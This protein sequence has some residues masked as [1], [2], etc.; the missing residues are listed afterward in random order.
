VSDSTR[1]FL[2]RHEGVSSERVTTIHNGIDTDIYQPR[3][4]RRA[5][6]R[7][8][9]GL[10]ANGTIVG[11]IGRLAYQKNFELF[12]NVAAQIPDA[13]FVIGGTGEDEAELRAQ[14][15]RL[16]LVERVKFLGYVGDMPS[17]WPALDCLLLTSRYEGLPI[18][19]LEAMACGVPIVASNLD[20]MREIL[21]DGENASL[22]P[23]SEIAPFVEAVRAFIDK[24]AHAAKLAAAALATVRADYSAARMARDVE[25]I[26]LRYLE[27]AQ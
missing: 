18:T 9:W 7:E 5:A 14:V 15:S 16:G 26:Y 3:P 25:A 23:P 4:E 6:S 12:L 1:D 24:P 21:R 22:V 2:V 17:L 11:G 10:P 27:G 13:F 8:K 20:G 19:I